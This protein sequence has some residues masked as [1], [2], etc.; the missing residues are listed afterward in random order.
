MNHIRGQRI[1]LTVRVEALGVTANPG[2]KGTVEGVGS[3]GYLTVR[4]DNGRRT[5]PHTDEVVVLS[6]PHR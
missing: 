1:Q 2:D 4:L 6:N 5:Y 3:D